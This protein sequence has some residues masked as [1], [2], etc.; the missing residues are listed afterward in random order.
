M[1]FVGD[2]LVGKESTRSVEAALLTW[3]LPSTLTSSSFLRWRSEPVC[4]GIGRRRVFRRNILLAATLKRAQRSIL[5]LAKTH[6]WARSGRPDLRS[7]FLRSPRR[8]RGPRHGP[9]AGAIRKKP[10]GAMT[11]AK[12]ACGSSPEVAGLVDGEAWTTLSEAEWLHDLNPRIAD[13]PRAA[14]VSGPSTTS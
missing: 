7:C 14:W 9:V 5:S 10:S 12:W 1:R 2:N 6:P 3:A 11:R 13:S 4:R 8:V